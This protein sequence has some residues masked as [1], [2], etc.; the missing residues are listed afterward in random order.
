MQGANRIHGTP[1]VAPA[2]AV[3][4]ASPTTSA[5][6][7]LNLPEA[8]SPSTPRRSRFALGAGGAGLVGRIARKSVMAV[9]VGS[10]LTMP[11]SAPPPGPPVEQVVVAQAPEGDEVAKFSEA[12]GEIAQAFAPGLTREQALNQLRYATV[13]IALDQGLTP[14]PDGTGLD[15]PPGTRLEVTLTRG[16]FT[17]RATPGV[18]WRADWAP[19]P[20]VSSI[21]YDFRSGSF[22]SDAEGIGPDSWYEG[23]INRLVD[24]HLRPRMPAA[25]QEPGYDPFSDPN[26]EDRLQQVVDLFTNTAS[27]AS[28]SGSASAPRFSFGFTIPDDVTIP[29]AEGA[30]E[31]NIQAGTRVDVG[32]RLEGSFS[33]LRLGNLTV[34]F[35]E[36]V[37][38][39]GAGEADA[40]LA[41]MDLSRFRLEPG[42]QV[43][44]E[45]RLGPEDA[46]DGVRAIGLLFAVLAEPR[47]AMRSDITFSSTQMEGLREDVQQRIDGELEPRLIQ[48]IRDQDEA[49]PGLSLMRLFG[50]DPAP[51]IA[52][53]G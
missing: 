40:I 44:L 24:Q 2:T 12:L 41:R 22:S 31:A 45:Y 14:G 8:P 5:S 18:Q 4:D 32:A 43:S 17:I 7:A 29:F 19:D 49:I 26:L 33:E 28:R 6:E 16:G 51:D 20:S 52:D 36:P 15:A 30:S 34:D 11:G 21:R 1:K 23:S 38:I 9:M 39:T 53:R 48:V 35:S 47:V 46:V 27:E 37:G 25:M 3:D 50:T 42:G 13:S 10:L